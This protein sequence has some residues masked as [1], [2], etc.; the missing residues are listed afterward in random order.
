MSSL[1]VFLQ[2]VLSRL[3][4]IAGGFALTFELLYG[5]KELSEKCHPSCYSIDVK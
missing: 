5:W 4:R 3:S 1:F 2:M